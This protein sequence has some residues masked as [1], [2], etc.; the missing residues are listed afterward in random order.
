MG[1]STAMGR[2]SKK[3]SK[4]KYRKLG[5]RTHKTCVKGMLRGGG[6]KRGGRRMATST[7]RRSKKGGILV[8]GK[9]YIK[10]SG[11]VSYT[12]KQMARKRA[13]ARKAIN[14]IFK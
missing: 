2:A 10:A 7:R 11:R 9:R 4:G 14:R 13:S 6:K 3:C 8:N 5:Y 1:K 12:R